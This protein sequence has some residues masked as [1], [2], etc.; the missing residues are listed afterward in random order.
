MA[1]RAVAEAGV[2]IRRRCDAHLTFLKRCVV[3]NAI[4]EQTKAMVLRDLRGGLFRLFS[5]VTSQ[6]KQP[7]NYIR[8]YVQK[9]LYLKVIFSMYKTEIIAIVLSF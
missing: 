3:R 5:E 4:V 7:L 9:L 6:K 2:E 1:L 8:V